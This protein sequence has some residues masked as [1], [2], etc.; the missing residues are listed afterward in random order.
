MR[1][2][3]NFKRDFFVIYSPKADSYAQDSDS[4]GDLDLW[5]FTIEQAHAKRFYMFHEAVSAFFAL[6]HYSRYQDWTILKL[7]ETTSVQCLEKFD[8]S[9]TI[10]ERGDTV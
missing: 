8:V 3:S 2:E 10:G 7:R 5:A 9:V 1:F 6:N 4:R